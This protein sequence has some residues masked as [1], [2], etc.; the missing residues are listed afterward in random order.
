MRH[1][2]IPLMVAVLSAGALF[3]PD[4]M[5]LRIDTPLKLSVRLIE[6]GVGKQE[7]A[8]PALA[9]LEGSLKRFKE[10]GYKLVGSKS[11]ITA[12]VEPS[13]IELPKDMVLEFTPLERDGKGKIK[14]ILRWTKKDKEQGVVTIMRLP[15]AWLEPDK[16]FLMAVENQEVYLL[17]VTVSPAGPPKDIERAPTPVPKEPKKEV[18][19]E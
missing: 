13:R 15:G 5:A 10:E 18:K 6:T 19:E 2:I 12:N 1:G 3:S 16:P 7:K 4:A 11:V 17:A 14:M 8:D 9:D